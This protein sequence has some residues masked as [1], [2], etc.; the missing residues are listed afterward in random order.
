MILND[1]NKDYQLYV[2]T[3]SLMIMIASADDNLENS[4]LKIIQE[5]ITDFY[6]IDKLVLDKIMIDT[7]ARE[8][9]PNIFPPS[10]LDVSPCVL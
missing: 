8:P 1:N 6:S 2:H 5:I 7:G 3:T 10:F 4:E 9:E